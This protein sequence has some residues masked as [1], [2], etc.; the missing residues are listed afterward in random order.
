MLK[1]GKT[2]RFRGFNKGKGVDGPAAQ[3][4]IA[5]IMICTIFIVMPI[6]ITISSS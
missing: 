1:K 4:T 6:L 3:I 5:V 2:E